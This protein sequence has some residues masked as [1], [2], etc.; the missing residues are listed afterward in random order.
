[1]TTYYDVLGVNAD[2]CTL[3]DIKKA[4]RALA[5][6]YHPDRVPAEMKEES[7]IKFRAVSEAY[8]V[9][10]DSK[11]RSDYDRS[12]KY[13]GGSDGGGDYNAGQQHQHQHQHQQQHQYYHNQHQHHRDPFSQFNDLFRNDPFFNDAFK[14][15]DD[16]FAK[17]FQQ[18]TNNNNNN[19]NVNNINRQQPNQK[20]NQNQNQRGWGGWLLDTVVDK[21]GIDL[22]VSSSSNT[23]AG[24]SHSTT[25]YGRRR[26]AASASVGTTRS[27]S[28]YT[29]KTT[30]TIIENGRR[31]TI[32]SM[33]KD[34][35]KI[36][37]KYEG[38]HLVQRLVN[39]RPQHIGRIEQG[40]GGGGDL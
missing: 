2:T 15:M 21:L 28:T 20:K 24:T 6:Q 39:G 40:G 5:L 27:T 37:E 8:E 25:N 29:S 22:Q 10:S 23:N 31:I 12:L 38:T 3:K 19:N 1:M 34:G 9:L 16:L 14:D 33:E 35:N 17:T 7:T 30:K 11:S 26:S 36:E 4:Y 18:Q 13:G 32:Q